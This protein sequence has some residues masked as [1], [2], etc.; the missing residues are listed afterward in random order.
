MLAGINLIYELTFQPTPPIPVYS[1]NG[2]TRLYKR[3]QGPAGQTGSLDV[4]TRRVG[5]A[6]GRDCDGHGTHWHLHNLLALVVTVQAD[7][8]NHAL[9][10]TWL[11]PLTVLIYVQSLDDKEW[12]WLAFQ[13][14]NLENASRDHGLQF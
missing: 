9:Y 14:P 4:L 1:L 13:T 7:T 12:F 3:H 10:T 2:S 11:S 8:V 6:G 5:V